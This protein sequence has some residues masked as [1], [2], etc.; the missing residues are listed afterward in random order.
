MMIIDSRFE[1]DSIFLADLSLSQLRLMNDGELDWF[2]LIPKREDIIEWSDLGQE[3]QL[4]LN[5]EI[6]ML[7]NLLKELPEVKKVN[8]ANL[9]NIVSQ[10]H[11]HI[12][13]RKFGDRAWPGPIWGTKSSLPL[14][15]ERIQFWKNAKISK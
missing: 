12:I 14:S 11:V 3:D 9:G 6:N 10:F 15:Q 4:L 8:V 5:Q 7:V 2:I 1:N 13:G